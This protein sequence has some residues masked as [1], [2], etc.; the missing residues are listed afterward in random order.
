VTATSQSTP[1]SL[2]CDY[3]GHEFGAHYPDSV[4]IEGYLWDADSGDADGLA[5]GGD[6]PCP[7]CNHSVWRDYHADNYFSDGYERAANWQ[8]PIRKSRYRR[9]WIW[10]GWHQLR[11]AVTRYW[12]VLRGRP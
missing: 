8:W 3:Q 7:Q 10:A 2:G 5:N 9:D 12:D 11:G 4:C 1:A 6:L